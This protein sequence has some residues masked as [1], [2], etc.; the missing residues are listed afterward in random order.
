M[1]ESKQGFKRHTAWQLH[2]M[3]GDVS[4][5][6]SQMQKWKTISLKKTQNPCPIPTQPFSPDNDWCETMENEGD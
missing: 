1:I 5:I 4:E 6:L 2:R 3:L